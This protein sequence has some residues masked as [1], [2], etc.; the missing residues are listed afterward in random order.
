M[1]DRIITSVSEVQWTSTKQ[2]RPLDSTSGTFIIARRTKWLAGSFGLMLPIIAVFAPVAWSFRDDS[3]I[4]WMTILPAVFAFLTML[5][6][7]YQLYITPKVLIEISGTQLICHPRRGE[8]V[9]L[10]LSEVVSVVKRRHMSANR[11]GNASAFYGKIVLKTNNG[12]LTIS[13]VANHNEVHKEL[14]ALVTSLR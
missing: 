4:M 9:E 7:A 3:M 14:Q 2:R 13:W 12:K 10:Q 1:Q 5:W 11:G 8:T 6:T